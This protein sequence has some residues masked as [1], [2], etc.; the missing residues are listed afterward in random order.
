[1]VCIGLTR[2]RFE[3]LVEDDARQIELD[4]TLRKRLQ[5]HWHDSFLLVIV[6]GIAG[7]L[8]NLCNKVFKNRC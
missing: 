4:R 6:C 1:M 5:T 2:R 7:Q 3:W 8:Q